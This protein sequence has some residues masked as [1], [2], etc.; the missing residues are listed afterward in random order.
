[1]RH[2]EAEAGPELPDRLF[3]DS[4]EV[5]WTLHV[6]LRARRRGE[7]SVPLILADGSPEDA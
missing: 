5:T 1:M 2:Y 6:S 4:I 3:L 7:I